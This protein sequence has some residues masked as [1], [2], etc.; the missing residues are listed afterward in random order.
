MLMK[1]SGWMKCAGMA[2]GMSAL[3]L[4]GC[5]QDN[6]GVD[7]LNTQV[8]S[9]QEKVDQQEQLLVNLA[10][11]F[12]RVQG[13]ATKFEYTEFNPQ[14]VRY[15]ILNNGIVS[16]LG[17]VA[18]VQPLEK[19]GTALTLRLA[20][21]NSITVN[22][23]GF[24]IT[25]GPALPQGDKVSPDQLKAWRDSLQSTAF[26]GQLVLRSGEWNEVTFNLPSVP[27]DKLGYVRLATTMDNVQFGN[28]PSPR[29]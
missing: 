18:K 21:S 25:W 14:Q 16:I 11:N 28:T 22:N 17:Q 7:E 24:A 12:V 19:G 5:Q 13:V 26:D 15:F 10:N 8:K 1:T 3:L 23:P 4:A 6:K 20:N 2:C 9:L 27:A 29:K